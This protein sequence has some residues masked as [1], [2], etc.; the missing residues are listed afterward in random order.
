MK[1][2]IAFL[3][4]LTLLMAGKTAAV[5]VS[6]PTWL[7][8]DGASGRILAGEQFDTPIFPA[9]TT[10]ILTALVLLEYVEPFDYVTVGPEITMVGWD[11]SIA[12]LVQGDILTVTDIVMAMMLP[13]G[14]DAAF[15][16]AVFTA[17]RAA[18]NPA[19]APEEALAKFA[20][21]MNETAGSLGASNSNFVTPCGFH[22]PEHYSTARD[23]AI[24][25]LAALE[26]PLI[27]R[28]ASTRE[29]ST[30]IVSSIGPTQ[31]S[32]QNTNQLLHPG[33]PYF[34]PEAIGLKS[35]RT[36]Q[37][38]FCLISLANRQ[39][40]EALVLVFG[41]S[42]EGR[43]QDSRLLLEHFFNHYQAETLGQKDVAA[44]IWG[45]LPVGPKTNQ[46]A[47][48]NREESESL[49]VEF[50]P[51][52]ALVGRNGPKRPLNQGQ[53]VGTLLWLV[54]QEVVA[55]EQALA[56]SDLPRPFLLR[57]IGLALMALPLLL[58]LLVHCHFRRQRRTLSRRYTYYRTR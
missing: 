12:R 24:I 41:G 58:L 46:M 8:V 14:N 34:Y 52:S 35:G 19:L 56:L 21:L 49:R 13:S 30:Q 55:Q 6:T 11:S 42:R 57:P 31:R 1:K 43:W 44:V 17:R 53:V 27:R 39:G 38:G 7:L 37:A 32:W 16:A 20:E 51:D 45:D 50:V 4:A 47:V 10:K 25:S 48:L 23:M 54:N 29:Y 15:T 40:L 18:G 26:V 36:A 33:S 22:H 9:S 5:N 3:L 28:A 2:L